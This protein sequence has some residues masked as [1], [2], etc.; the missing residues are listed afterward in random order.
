MSLA[1]GQQ[2]TAEVLGSML[3][4]QQR[5]GEGGAGHGLSC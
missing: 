1:L 4:V 2:V 3:T 5:L